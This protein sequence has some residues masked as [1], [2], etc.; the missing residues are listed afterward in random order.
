M[1]KLRLS[2]ACGDYDI[3]KPL[4][5]GTVQADGLYFSPTWGRAS[6]TGGWAE[7]TSSTFAKRTSAP[8]S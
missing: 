8:T 6:A 5:E 2:V 4:I 7:S 1:A 3:V